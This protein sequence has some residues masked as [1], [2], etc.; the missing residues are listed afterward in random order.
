MYEFS[1]VQSR[2][3]PDCINVC[4]TASKKK[5]IDCNNLIKF[6]SVITIVRKMSRAF[7][8]LSYY[9]SLNF[10]AMGVVMGHELTHGFDDQGVL[11][12]YLEILYMYCI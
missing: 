6:F 11:S 1:Q 10:G 3:Y 8:L 12:V 9:R 2:D 4:L 5:K 7:C